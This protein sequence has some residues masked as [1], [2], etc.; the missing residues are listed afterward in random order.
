MWKLVWLVPSILSHVTLIAW[1]REGTELDTAVLSLKG[2]NA[3]SPHPGSFFRVK[4]SS[5][6]LSRNRVPGNRGKNRKRLFHSLDF[7]QLLR[8]TWSHG[9]ELRYPRLFPQVTG[10]LA[11]NHLSCRKSFK[12]VLGTTL[13]IHLNDCCRLP[14]DPRMVWSDTSTFLLYLSRYIKKHSSIK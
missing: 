9:I 1:Q 8:R 11:F 14:R 12:W 4:T 2:A 13:L 6:S 3:Q 5:L 7:H 10:W